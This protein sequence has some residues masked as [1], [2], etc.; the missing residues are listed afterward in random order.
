MPSAMIPEKIDA[1]NVYIDDNKLVGISAETTLPD[2]EAITETISGPGILGEIESPATGQFGPMEMEIPFRVIY[3]EIGSLMMISK[4]TSITL[5]GSMQVT[6]SSDTS[7]SNVPVRIVIRGKCKK[8]TSGKMAQG[9]AMESSVTFEILYILIE[10]NGVT[11]VE[12]DK[13]NF[14]YTLNGEDQLALIRSQC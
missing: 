14:V 11:Q 9:K 13:L 6:D 7:I 10:V 4:A 1:Y 5:R 12:L 3:Q 2:F 8:T